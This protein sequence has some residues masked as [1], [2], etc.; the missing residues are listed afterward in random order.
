M[1]RRL[2][3]PKALNEQDA[4]RI[5]EPAALAVLILCGIIIVYG[6]LNLTLVPL[7]D[8][9]IFLGAGGIIFGVV[10]FISVV[11]HPQRLQKW[12][13]PI[14][15][16]NAVF[17]IINL[18]VLPEEFD[19]IAHIALI[20]TSAIFTII[21]DQKVAYGLI[22][23][24]LIFYVP[25]S[26][27]RARLFDNVQDLSLYLLAL[28]FI[29]IIHRL[30][31]ANMHRIR[32]LQT[33]NEF[34]R[35]ISSSLEQE[36][37]IALVGA[38]IQKAIEAD[39]YFLGLV[40]SDQIYLHM[41]YDD[42]EYF[43]PT[44]VSMDGTLSGWVIRNQRSL[45]IP[46]MRQDVNLEG[47]QV[48]LT[49]NNRNNESW[50]G[51]PMRAEHVNGVIVTASYTRYAFDRTDLELLEILSQHAALAL[52]NAYHHAEVEAQSLRDSLTGAFNHSHIIKILREETEKVQ[53][54]GKP[55][56]LIMLDIDY[57][58]QYNDNYGHQVGD[59]VLTSLT[60]AIRVHI[61]ASDSLG[62]WGGEEFT[63]VLPGASGVQAMQVAQRVQE[64]VNTLTIPYK[65]GTLPFPTV[66]QGVAVFPTETGDVDQLIHLADQR[67]YI[68]KQR[69]RNQIEPSS[70][71]WD[72]IQG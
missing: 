3:S 69:G 15:A 54:T 60:K 48:I 13:W 68:A 27:N 1:F 29:T 32:R 22:F 25:S 42:G 33:I 14:V 50:M 72:K 51:V 39:T 16:A 23:S 57:F 11:P 53:L 66:S 19:I 56:S 30:N 36:Q 26:F 63:I 34:A 12:K 62:R 6:I 17:L 67:L 38:A 64:T 45:F 58:K 7:A 55:V 61:K 31:E 40:N 70:E 18:A 28:V 47:V 10:L 8:Q 5:A 59:N 41:I 43:P 65:D 35:Q 2:L 24:V 71:H 9:A 44:E 49:G 20:L 21:W 46:D 37:V 52:D 4:R